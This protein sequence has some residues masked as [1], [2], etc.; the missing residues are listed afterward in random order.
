MSNYRI[1]HKIPKGPE[2]INGYNSG[3]SPFDYGK[4]PE[5]KEWVPSYK[6]LNG[7]R[8]RGYCRDKK[9]NKSGYSA[10][11][12]ETNVTSIKNEPD[13]RGVLPKGRHKHGYIVTSFNPDGISIAE[14]FFPSRRKAEKHKREVEKGEYF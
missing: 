4:C 11:I 12:R 1:D 13:E 3:K 6:K 10:E 8:V 7:E 9:E 14:D 2:S 5:G